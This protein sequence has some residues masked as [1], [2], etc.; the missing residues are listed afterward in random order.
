MT[1]LAKCIRGT[2]KIIEFSKNNKMK[3]GIY[4]V[5]AVVIWLSLLINTT[6]IVVTALSLTITSGLYL[7]AV[8]KGEDA[9]KSGILSQEGIA[10]SVIARV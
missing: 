3:V 7:G 1:F 5:S 9:T 6:A 4:S 8:V 2:D 10:R